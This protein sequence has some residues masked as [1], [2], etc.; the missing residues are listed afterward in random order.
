[1]SDAAAV[2]RA[3]SETVVDELA[4]NGL[5]HV[6]IS[7]GSRS[8]P[9]ALAFHLDDRIKKHVHL[10]E[11]SAAFFALGV[12]KA[13]GVPAA[14]LCTSGT[15]PA[16]LY[17]A[18]VEARQS[19][20]PMLVL[21]ADRP[22]ELRAT[23]A[24][25][26]IDQL[27]MFGDSVVWFAETGTPES[28][29]RAPGYWRSLVC[30]AVAAGLGVPRG[31][32]H[33]NIPLREPLYPG[34]GTEPFPYPHE[35]R[36]DG[37]PW[38]EIAGP[39]VI[40]DGDAIDRLARRL[41][42]T[43]R[44]AVVAGASAR[45]LT[46]LVDLAAAL[47][48]PL[49]AEPASNLRAPGTVSTYDALLRAEAFLESHTPEVILRA[50]KLSLGRPLAA[51]LRRVPQLVID[52]DGIPFDEHRTA[53]LVVGG[54]PSSIATEVLDRLNPSPE[55]SWL[56][57]WRSADASASQAIDAVIASF[58][59][60]SEPAVA[61]AVTASL[62]SGANLFVASSMPVRDVESFMAPR[63]DVKVFANRGANGIDGVVST[64]LGIAAASDAPTF[65]LVGDIALLHDANGF[66]SADSEAT[67]VV[68]NNDGGGIFSFLE[69]AGADGFE[70]V[71]GTPHGRDLAT[72]ASF[73]RLHYE[74]ITM[75]DALE[76]A[77]ARGARSLIE[78]RTDRSSNIDHHRALWKAVA[79]AL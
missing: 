21:T 44:G 60:P 14:V 43:T 67:F 7:P 22:P 8:G 34:P 2:N 9:L 23:G 41:S 49:L 53:E 54:H 56:T 17:P 6:C 13:T 3:F 11:R 55:D 28:S 19:G 61:R 30:R 47:G 40:P 31:P 73:H 79:D 12:A 62:P 20:V 70:R 59:A 38:T 26:T 15:A 74:R 65:A 57:S 29:E 27:K 72:L 24:N 71:F 64:T 32:V 25:Q 18:V 78:V 1:M 39:S 69:Q 50:G 16:N 66:L 58:D 35:G 76:P 4:R 5:S 10:D 68:V 33:L 37:L 51:L 36:A 48:W 46:G 45:D 63:D 75:M 52:A 77:L 42:S